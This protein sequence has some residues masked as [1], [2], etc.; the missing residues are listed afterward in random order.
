MFVCGGQM[1]FLYRFFD[2][3][4]QLLYVGITHRVE[5][6]FAGHQRKK[7]WHLVARIQIEQFPTREEAAQAERLAIQT[8][9]PIWNIALATAPL[10]IFGCDHCHRPLKSL[11][12]GWNDKRYCSRCWDTVDPS[13]RWF[14]LDPR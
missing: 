11:F 8:E 1:T 5:S 9:H 10:P 13:V 6:R 7:P 3:D 4:N 14:G 12:F 2:S